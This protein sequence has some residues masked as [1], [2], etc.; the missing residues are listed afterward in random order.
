[1]THMLFIHW[2]DRS[3][4]P[5]T[6]LVEKSE[7]DSITK[8]CLEL[9]EKHRRDDIRQA[10][11]K[12]GK[13]VVRLNYTRDD[14]IVYCV[15]L[16]AVPKK[17]DR[18]YT[19]ILSSMSLLFCNTV[20]NVKKLLSDHDISPSPKSI[21]KLRDDGQ[22]L[23]GL[24]DNMAYV[25]VVNVTDDV[26]DE[27]EPDGELDENTLHQECLESLKLMSID[28]IKKRIKTDKLWSEG[29]FDMQTFSDTGVCELDGCTTHEM[30]I[31]QVICFRFLGT[32]HHICEYC[33]KHADADDIIDIVLYNCDTESESLLKKLDMKQITK[34]FVSGKPCNY[35]DDADKTT[36]I[37]GWQDSFGKCMKKGCT[38]LVNR[39]LGTDI[40]LCSDHL[41]L[42]KK[43][44]DQFEKYYPDDQ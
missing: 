33:F 21:K 23:I 43:Y 15:S 14:N 12:L 42:S 36:T 30:D 27:I 40:C 1:M 39:F 20:D 29:T 13:K 35:T 26:D 16:I 18:Y 34:M 38:E 3:Q 17:L 4:P 37:Y 7:R 32:G 19:I 6:L 41:E 28:K 22:V 11:G 8:K 9:T 31:T 24:D 5:K 25:Y 2:P 10:V 44:I